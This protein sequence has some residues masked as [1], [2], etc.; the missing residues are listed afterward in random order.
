MCFDFCC[1]VLLADEPASA[2]SHLPPHSRK[3][4]VVCVLPEKSMC[5]FSNLVRGRDRR[6]VVPGRL[7]GKA[8]LK[9]LLKGTDQL[10]DSD[11]FLW[12]ESVG[13]AVAMQ[14]SSHAD[15]AF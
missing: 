10:N 11:F 14:S 7:V 15:D 4:M 13:R 1:L 9:E 12:V 2:S 3:H 5:P 8:T 6:G